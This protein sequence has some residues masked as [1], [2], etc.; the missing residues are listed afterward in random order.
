M[1]VQ[2]E[3]ILSSISVLPKEYVATANALGRIIAEPVRSRAM[4]PESDVAAVDGYA[5]R[6]SDLT[7]FPAIVRVIGESSS[8]KPFSGKIEHGTAVKTYAGGKIPAGA[9][10]V[11]AL[12]KV[13]VEGDTVI[14]QESQSLGENVCPQGV[15]FSPHDIGFEQG[16]VMNARLI[17]LASAMNLLWL[18]V[19]RKPRVAVLAV[20]SE[21]AM[22][23][24]ASAANPITASSLYT[25]PANIVASCGDPIVLG[26]ATDSVDAVIEKIEEAKNCDLIIT[27][28]GTSAAAGKLMTRVLDKLSSD[29]QLVRTELM[30]NDHMLFTRYKGAPICALPGNPISSSIY[31]SVFTR[32]VINKMLGV[33]NPAKNFAVLSRGLDKYDTNLA[34]LH[35]SIEI[36]TSG[37]RKITPVSAQDGFLLSKLVQSDC[38]LIVNQNKDLK[39]GDLVEY[40]P[41]FYSLV[42]A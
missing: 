10:T 17:G 38:L 22:P 27:T 3:S 39:K 33:R 25:L 29:V 4:S 42:S 12:S 13:L 8:V 19:V 32:P 23:G 41:L 2:F 1:T 35:A 31:F 36:D 5:V 11:I 18:P 16:T 37:V 40:L 20:G 24:E 15:D 9:D 7:A 30:R 34:Y 21:L 28:G 6:F 26:I 14:I